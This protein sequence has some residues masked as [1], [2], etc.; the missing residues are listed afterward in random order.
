MLREG[1]GE[2][3]RNRGRRNAYLPGGYLREVVRSIDREAGREGR[4]EE[5][6]EGGHIA[7]PDASFPECY[8]TLLRDTRQI[9]YTGSLEEAYL[10]QGQFSVEAEG[11]LL[12]RWLHVADR[13]Y[14]FIL[15]TGVSVDTRVMV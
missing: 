13:V 11:G 4:R 14:L 2:G 3:E 1:K 6:R 5:G 9:F 12:P 10:V 7:F 8:R 15:K